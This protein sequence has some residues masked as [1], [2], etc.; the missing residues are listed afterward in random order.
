MPAIFSIIQKITLHCPLLS[1]HGIKWVHCSN[2]QFSMHTICSAADV[3]HRNH[4][5]IRMYKK[6]WKQKELLY[7]NASKKEL[8]SASLVPS[9]MTG[10]IKLIFAAE[11]CCSWIPIFLLTF[12]T[13]N[14]SYACVIRNYILQMHSHFHF[15]WPAFVIVYSLRFTLSLFRRRKNYFKFHFV[16]NRSRKRPHK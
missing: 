2:V 3:T 14:N 15:D 9:V 16:I 13:Q 12:G 10:S 8:A 1:M 7:C 5:P 6:N 11:K 4:W